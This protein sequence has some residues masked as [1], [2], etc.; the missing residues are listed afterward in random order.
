[1]GEVSEM[2]D[3]NPSLIRF[4]EQKFDILKPKKNAKGNR[5]FTPADIENL[6]LIYH[7]VKENG[8]TLDGAQKRIKENRSGISKG[9]E[10]LERLEGVKSLLLEIK[11]ELVRSGGNEILID[12]MQDNTAIEKATECETCVNGGIATDSE[13]SLNA[14]MVTESETAGGEEVKA[15]FHIVEL[16]EEF[17]GERVASYDSMLSTQGIKSASE[18][19]PAPEIAD[20]TEPIEPIEPTA[21]APH[22]SRP[23][24][25]DQTLF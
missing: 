6:K 20:K 14:E 10:V 7:L 24:A 8:M 25:I 4:W 17:T 22:S 16:F 21:P 18:R 11:Q 9:M 13:T 1:M 3:V 19:E 12:E 2:F 5:M 23:Q 15:P